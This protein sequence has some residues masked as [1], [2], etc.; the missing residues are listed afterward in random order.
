LSGSTKSRTQGY[1]NSS[2]KFSNPLAFVGRTVET[3]RGD[4]RGESLAENL[5]VDLRSPS[6]VRYRYS[7]PKTGARHRLKKENSGIRD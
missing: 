4:D 5:D 3:F 7:S 2:F 6:T 1:T